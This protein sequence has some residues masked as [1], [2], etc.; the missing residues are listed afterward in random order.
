[1]LHIETYYILFMSLTILAGAIAIPVIIVEVIH[2]VIN[3]K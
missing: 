3:R 1:M 2:R